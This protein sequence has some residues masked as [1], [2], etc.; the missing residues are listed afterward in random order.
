MAGRS[1]ILGGIQY[2]IWLNYL[3]IYPFIPIDTLTLSL[4]GKLHVQQMQRKGRKCIGE[5]CECYLLGK[6]TTINNLTVS[7]V[8]SQVRTRGWAH[9]APPPFKLLDTNNYS[10]RGS[11]CFQLCSLLVSLPDS[12]GWSPAPN[13][14]SHE[15]GKAYREEGLAAMGENKEITGRLL[16][17]MKMKYRYETAKK[18]IN[19]IKNEPPPKNG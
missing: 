7:A 10:R 11:H 2:F 18:Q 1:Y 15:C 16:R 3:Q 14:N 17:V 4:W 5:G 8:N 12:K 9:T 13:T 19:L 6:T